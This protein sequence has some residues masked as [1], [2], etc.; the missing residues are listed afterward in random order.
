F[1][2]CSAARRR[3]TS[4]RESPPLPPEKILW[5]ISVRLDL[6]IYLSLLLKAPAWP[7]RAGPYVPTP[8]WLL[9]NAGENCPSIRAARSR[10]TAAPHPLYTATI[11]SARRLAGL[12]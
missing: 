3:S 4:A 6:R 9:H 2:W 7:A 8:L 10:Q 5:T 11:E 12:R 1:R